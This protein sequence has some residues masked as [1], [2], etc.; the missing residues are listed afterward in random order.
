[1]QR[2]II[3]Q[4]QAHINAGQIWWEFSRILSTTCF[5]S[6]RKV[7]ILVRLMIPSARPRMPLSSTTLMPL[8]LRVAH[9]TYRTAIGSTWHSPGLKEH[10]QTSIS[11]SATL[12]LTVAHL[13]ERQPGLRQQSIQI[14]VNAP[15]RRHRSCSK[16][17]KIPIS[18]FILKRKRARF[19]STEA[20]QVESR[21]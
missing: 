14:Q 20:L 8:V 18:L 13:P 19:F 5:P 10:S 12:D 17:F 1:M 3:E 21:L 7:V 4:P 9:F 16:R 6:S 11:L 15:L 2:R